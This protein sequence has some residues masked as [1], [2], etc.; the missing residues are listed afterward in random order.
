MKWVIMMLLQILK[1]MISINI[2]FGKVKNSN[3][4]DIGIQKICI[5]LK[6]ILTKDNYNFVSLV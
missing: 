6:K 4:V 1:K 3:I 5:T 2:I